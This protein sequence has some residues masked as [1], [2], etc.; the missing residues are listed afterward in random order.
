MDV[1][2]LEN[3]LVPLFAIQEFDDDSQDMIAS[4]QELPPPISDLQL[5]LSKEL[6]LKLAHRICV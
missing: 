4:K 6:K 3:G 1:H 2:S 5:Q